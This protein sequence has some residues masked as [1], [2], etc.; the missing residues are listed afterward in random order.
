M[1]RSGR[2]EWAGRWAMGKGIRLQEQPSVM[3]AQHVLIIRTACA[4]LTRMIKD[5]KPAGCW[6]HL[7]L[8]AAMACS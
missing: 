6:R 7:G 1:S 2:A 4:V 8:Y 3:S 5:D